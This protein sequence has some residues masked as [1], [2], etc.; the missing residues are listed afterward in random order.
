MVVAGRY[1]VG[2]QGAV[3]N[4]NF[5]DEQASIDLVAAL[6]ARLGGEV[7]VTAAD[8][9]ALPKPYYGLSVTFEPGF[10]RYTFRVREPV[11]EG[12]A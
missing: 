5:E 12:G 7:T 1:V 2:Q 8:I 4:I 11:Q 3:M 6:V 10:D 9:D